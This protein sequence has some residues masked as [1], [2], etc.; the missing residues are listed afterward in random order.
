M[1]RQIP[2]RHRTWLVAGT[3]VGV[4]VLGWT[5]ADARPRAYLGGLFADAVGDRAAAFDH[6]A[7]AWHLDPRFLDVDARIAAAADQLIVELPLGDMA[8]EVRLLRWL[9]ATGRSTCLQ[10]PS[11]AV[12]F[13]SPVG[14]PCSVRRL[15]RS[16]SRRS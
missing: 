14:H 1:N 3:L 16:G 15:R 9:A 6:F 10:Q 13:P 12:A 7:D 8:L 2:L 4:L 11:A 5:L